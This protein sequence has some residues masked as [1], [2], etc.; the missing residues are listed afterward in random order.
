MIAPHVVIVTGN[1]DYIQTDKPM[2]FAGIV[3]ADN[4]T[5]NYDVWIGANVTIC[6]GVCE[7][8]KGAVIGAG[9]V[10]TKSVPPYAVV[11]G[12]PAKVI[13]YRKN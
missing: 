7:I 6:P 4:L 9:S 2:R 3:K 13:K 12:V 11:A 5:I 10:V 8:G 1:H